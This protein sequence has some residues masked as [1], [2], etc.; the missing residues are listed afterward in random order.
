MGRGLGYLSGGFGRVVITSGGGWRWTEREPL[1]SSKNR[2]GCAAF[3]Q[4]ERIF[5]TPKEC[6]WQLVWSSYRTCGWHP[7]TLQKTKIPKAH[8]LQAKLQTVQWLRAGP[9]HSAQVFQHLWHLPF[10]SNCP[11]SLVGCSLASYKAAEA[12]KNGKTTIY[13]YTKSQSLLPDF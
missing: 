6:C 4:S 12:R 2:R 7:N 10:F 5:E 11:D 1:H 13:I 3:T 8:S 9:L